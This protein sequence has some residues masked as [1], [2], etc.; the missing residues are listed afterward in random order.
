MVQAGSIHNNTV[1]VPRVPCAWGCLG[2]YP[3]QALIQLNST[4]IYLQI[5]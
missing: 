4:Q 2:V 5:T 1:A 3:E